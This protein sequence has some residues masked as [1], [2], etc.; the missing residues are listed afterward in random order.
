M[1]GDR[2]EERDAVRTTIVG[3]RPPGS[4]KDI[5]EIP[6]GIEVLVSKASVD[7]EFRTLLL[8]RRAS[9]ADEIGLDLSP[10]ESRML[11]AIPA[12]QLEAVIGRTK[13]APSNRRAFL[14]RAAAVMLAALGAGL[15][16]GEAEGGLTAGI[17][18]DR[19]RKLKERRFVYVETGIH[20]AP[21]ASYALADTAGLNSRGQE[22][23]RMNRLLPRAAQLSRQAW[24][25]DAAREG[26]PFPVT[27]ARPFRIRTLGEFPN[28]ADAA[29]FLEKQRA[30]HRERMAAFALE[31]KK[32]L[33]ALTRSERQKEEA[34]LE[35]LRAAEALIARKLE[36]LI[37][38]GYAPPPVTRGIRP[39]RPPVSEGIR[40]DPPPPTRGTRPDRP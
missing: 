35:A 12:V 29:K 9:A 28:E 5:G 3:G 6:R 40:P 21:A 8:D 13:V 34:R 26:T 17:S 7:A 4:G 11:D 25:K 2:P 33:A 32:R 24:E 15:G 20:E 22:I 37:E 23:A 18:P 19:I 30:T 16:A 10:A 31:Q 14:G 27:P 36:E 38:T 1:G 39:D